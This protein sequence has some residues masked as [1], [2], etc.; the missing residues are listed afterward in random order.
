MAAP[1]ATPTAAPVATAAAVPAPEEELA[2]DEELP[3]LIEMPPLLLFFSSASVFLAA[4]EELPDD[5]DE[6]LLPPLAALRPGATARQRPSAAI[7]AV[8]RNAVM[9]RSPLLSCRQ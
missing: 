1:A 9:V 5:F 6:D 4:L 3:V 7:R 2:D 8:W